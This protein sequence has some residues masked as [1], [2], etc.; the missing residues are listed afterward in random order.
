MEQFKEA[1]KYIPGGVNSPIRA[2]KEVFG[3]PLFIKKGKGS[4]IYDENNNEY[5]DFCMSY[6]PLIL[7][8]VHPRMIKAVKKAL[9]NGT[10]FGAPTKKETQLA[11]LIV[12]AVPSID[13][14]RLVNSGTEAVLSA[15]RL[16]RGFTKKDKIIKF[17]GCYH[18]HVDDLLTKKDSQNTLIAGFNNIKSV[19][20]TINNKKNKNKIAAVIV[21][22]IPGNMGVVLP[23]DNF[24][25]QLKEITNKNNILL[26][27][28]EVITGFRVSFGGA[29][30]LYNIKPD[31]TT[32]GKIIGGGLPVGAFGG[33]KEIMNLL[34]P[35]GP[36]YQA[37]TL[38]GNPIAT[39]AGI[40]TLKI[41]KNKSIYNQLNK[42]TNELTT[43]L[44]NNKIKINKIASMFTIF[45]NKN[46]KINNYKKAKK[47]NIKLFAKFHKELLKNNIYF[48]PSQFEAC[49][50]S[51][52]HS[53]QDIKYTTQAINNA[54]D[55]INS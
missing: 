43:S 16:A 24:L 6:G 27:F 31:I 26:I 19:K 47:S 2:F 45:F 17:D 4:K 36:V 49:F 8:H 18:G 7:G 33:K 15:V 34:S 12:D 30:K 10:S 13:K 46:K 14:V 5:I 48:P 38:S 41:L 54:L 29:Q 1:K 40:E 9:D 39:T 51:V 23:E 55:K 37:G 11:K 28:D 21:E 3:K 42:K 53:N 50:L 25:E 32:L 44:K 35:D 52:A 20:Q 22:P